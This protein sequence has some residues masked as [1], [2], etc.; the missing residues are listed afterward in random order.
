MSLLLAG[1]VVMISQILQQFPL[2]KMEHHVLFSFLM[3]PYFQDTHALK[4][5]Q[6]IFDSG[7]DQRLL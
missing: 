2:Q 5:S 6:E 7:E 3:K 4:H 1:L